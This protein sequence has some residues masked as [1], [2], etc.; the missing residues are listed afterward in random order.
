MVLWEGF[1][2]DGR[3]PVTITVEYDKEDDLYIVEVKRGLDVDF[4]T[5]EPKH[6]PTEGLMHVSDVEKAVKLA[7][8]LEKKLRQ[9]AYRRNS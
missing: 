3:I 2:H 7:N 9:A 5:F 1:H 4:K 6:V 8:I